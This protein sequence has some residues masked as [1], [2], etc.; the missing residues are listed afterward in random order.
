MIRLSKILS[1][2]S[3]G[4]LISLLSTEAHATKGESP[5]S[6]QESSTSKGETPSQAS[7][8]QNLSSTSSQTSKITNFGAQR[9]GTSELFQSFKKD[10][11]AALG[12]D[13][14]A[15]KRLYSAKSS[16]RIRVPFGAGYLIEEHVKK[17]NPIAQAL[18]G[19]I[20][21]YGCTYEAQNS[22]TSPASPEVAFKLFTLSAEQ[23]N[24]RARSHLGMLQVNRGNIDEGI[25]LLTQAADQNDPIARRVLGQY[26]FNGWKNSQGT[27]ILPDR[28]K[29]VNLLVSA[30]DQNDPIAQC[31]LGQC[32]FNGWTNN[33]GT[34]VLPDREKGVN[35]LVSAADQNDP[36]AQRL[37]G[38][39]YFNG[40]T[41]NQ[42]T[43]VLPDPENGVKLLSLAAN[44]GD[45][46]AQK[47][48][49]EISCDGWTNKRG[50]TVLPNPEKGIELFTLAANK[51]N[52][53]A[54]FLLGTMH[55]NG[56]EKQG[57]TKVP[58]DIEKGL[59]FLTKAADRGNAKA[60][61]A[62]GTTYIKK[63]TKCD[64]T[65]IQPNYRKAFNHLYRAPHKEVEAYLKKFFL[66]SKEEA[67]RGAPLSPPIDLGH[68]K[69][70]IEEKLVR[71]INSD[72]R[73]ERNFS[74][75]RQVYHVCKNGKTSMPLALCSQGCIFESMPEGKKEIKAESKEKIMEES[76]N[77]H[78][79]TKSEALFYGDSYR[80]LH[81]LPEDR[82]K[83]QEFYSKGRMALLRVGRGDNL[84]KLLLGGQTL[85]K[86]PISMARK[87]PVFASPKNL[88]AEAVHDELRLYK[89]K[90]QPF[91]TLGNANVRMVDDFMRGLVATE[92]ISSHNKTRADELLLKASILENPRDEVK[93]SK[94]NQHSATL[95]FGKDVVEKRI[96]QNI[97]IAR[98]FRQKAEKALKK[99]QDLQ[100]VENSFYEILEKV[101]P[102]K[103]KLVRQSHAFLP[104]LGEQ[105]E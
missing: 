39:Y 42:G 77:F 10:F 40:W 5:E 76:I 97:E 22:V 55:I 15:E 93:I 75:Q 27:T 19:M 83:F 63:W 89:L 104:S 50:M 61:I 100:Q 85:V 74:G 25:L 72:R 14:E 67:K 7:S 37:L 65:T 64:G 49:G 36:I 35:L 48:L 23:G 58:R 24:A 32:Y 73:W 28:E 80:T 84:S 38:Q 103:R 92:E 17:N 9:E 43:K 71:F 56:W 2:S 57:G 70:D 95:S 60:H 26:Y 62:L 3:M 82:A 102:H 91:L 12:G 13:S 33:Q 99:H 88:D 1:F 8:P 66:T 20:C 31:S 101:Q 6:A 45:S 96:A 54:Q 90:K 30:V 52:A 68:I 21:H 79:E 11:L 94:H 44:Q 16:Y 69:Q 46:V 98:V 34:K 86:I 47:I 41:N 4:V 18:K 53:E 29:G 105:E 78:F 81:D 87:L 51:G 59:E